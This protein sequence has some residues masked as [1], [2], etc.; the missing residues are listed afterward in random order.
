MQ[1]KPRLVKP[2]PKSKSKPRVSKP[3]PLRLTLEDELLVRL[4][5]LVPK[6]GCSAAAREFGIVADR[7]LVARVALLRGLS[8]MEAGE[9]SGRVA[10]P[11]ALHGASSSPEPEATP[12]AS[13]SELPFKAKEVIV[14]GDDGLVSTPEGWNRW[15]SSE[16]IPAAHTEVHEYYTAG[17]WQRFWGR[18]GDEVIA[19]YWSPDPELQ[20]LPSYKSLDKDGKEIKLQDTPF[21][22]GHMIPHGWAG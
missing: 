22:P 20:G 18:A 4:D 14:I 19:F 3:T 13:T 2:K 10:P 17:G 15:G 6:V 11:P 5:A 21:G 8:M 12:L 9:V 7:H 16:R 1:K